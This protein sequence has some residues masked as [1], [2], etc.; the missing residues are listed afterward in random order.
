MKN[1]RALKGK[2]Y[3]AFIALLCAFASVGVATFA[4]YIYNTSAHTTNLQMAAGTYSS[5]VISDNYDGPYSTSVSD[6]EVGSLIPVSTD[7]IQN[8]FQECADTRP[9]QGSEPS[10]VAY[11][12]KPAERKDYF[13]KTMYLRSGT[14]DLNVYVNIGFDDSKETNPISTAIR[15]G[16]LVYQPGSETNVEKE[17]IFAINPDQHVQTPQYNTEKG[18]EGYVLDSTDK[19]GKGSV[20]KFDPRT[21]NDYYKFDEDSGSVDTTG[22]LSLFTCPGSD[23]GEGTPVRVDAYIWLEGCDQ[24]CYGTMGT[25]SN[26]AIQ[27]AGKS[28]NN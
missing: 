2:L 13:I 17:Y 22:A 25:L 23:S 10:I 27:F 1:S 28:P 20:V 11:L 9:G 7:K 12:F 24:D 4:W 5:L 15:V 26:L 16:F 14:D 8:G 19:E 6:F 21:P 3:I 18:Q